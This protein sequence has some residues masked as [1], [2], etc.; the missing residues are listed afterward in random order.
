MFA[1]RVV[2]DCYWAPISLN[3]LVFDL[4]FPHILEVPSDEAATG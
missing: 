1:D 2:L 4:I 3:Q